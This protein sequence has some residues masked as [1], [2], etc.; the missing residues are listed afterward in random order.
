MKFLSK[1]Y[2]FQANNK[3]LVKFSLDLPDD[4]PALLLPTQRLSQASWLTPGNAAAIWSVRRFNLPDCQPHPVRPLT[5][6][7]LA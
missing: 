6:S 7:E 3:D 5:N 1:P 2:C 4:L